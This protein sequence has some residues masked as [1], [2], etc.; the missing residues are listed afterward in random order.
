MNFRQ[1]NSDFDRI[2]KRGKSVLWIFLVIF[3]IGIFSF[4]APRNFLFGIGGPLWGVKNSVTSFFSSNIN[5]LQSKSAL[6]IQNNLLKREI[7]NN[8]EDQLLATAL[9]NENTDLKNILNR[10]NQTQKE[11]LAAVVAKPFF[12]PYDTLV[13]DLGSADGIAIGDQVIA[14]GDTYIGYI[15]QVYNLSSKVVLYSSSGET[16][17]I[18]IGTDTIEK[19][20]TGMGGG[21]F[22]AQAP[23]GSNISIGDPIVIP[24]ISPNI[25]STVEKVQ[26]KS[27]DS[28]ETI[29]FKNPVNISELQW[30]EVIPT[31]SKNK[32]S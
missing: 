9:L 27:T 3:L 16:I 7:Q 4:Q 28:F 5:L 22:S 18:L 13:I 23:I 11:I 25:F 8:Q 30:V 1:R 17:N 6:I 32:T 20:A 31:N 29:L 19:T 12:S 26:S 15:S 14:L 24:S 21:N 10:K 2:D